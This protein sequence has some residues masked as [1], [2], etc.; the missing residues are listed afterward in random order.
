MPE[1]ASVRKRRA[2]ERRAPGES[3]ASKP[4]SAAAPSTA[5]WQR[6]KGWNVH[7]SAEPH[8]KMV[9]HTDGGS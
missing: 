9:A 6:V 1:S 4:G 5:W 8:R 7:Q 3:K 2:A